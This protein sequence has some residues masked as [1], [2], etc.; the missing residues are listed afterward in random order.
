LFLGHWYSAK[1]TLTAVLGSV[2]SYGGLA[3]CWRDTF[4]LAQT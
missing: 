1:P 4:S 2:T 3:P